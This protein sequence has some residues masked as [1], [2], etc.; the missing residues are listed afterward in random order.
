VTLDVALRVR[1]YL[2]DQGVKVIMVRTT[3]TQLSVNKKADL[4]R[5]SN[6]ATADRVNAYIAIHVNSG[7]SSASGI[8][9]YYFGQAMSGTNQSLA[10]RENGGG[11]VGEA[12]TKQANSAA[13][14]LVGAHRRRRP[15]REIRRPGGDQEPTLARHPDRDW[16]WQQP[17]RGGKTRSGRVQR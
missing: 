14:G 11:S 5:R 8:E 1:R 10:V 7:S 4:L 15:G 9:T 2:Q 12:I 13:Q 16:I 3:D 17:L 6:L